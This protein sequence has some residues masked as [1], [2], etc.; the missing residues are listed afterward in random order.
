[1]ATDDFVR[2]RLDGMTDL[3]HSS[4]AIG[5]RTPWSQIE[6]SL[7]PLSARKAQ[8]GQSREDTNTFSPALVVAAPADS[9]DGRTAVSQAR[10]QQGRTSR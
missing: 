1:M 3:R 7:P 10:R 5:R 6:A 8:M 4:A 2:A 9:A